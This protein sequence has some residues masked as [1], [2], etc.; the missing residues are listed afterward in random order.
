MTLGRERADQA[1]SQGAVDA[2]THIAL[3]NLY[4]A[5]NYH[6][7]MVGLRYRLGS[8]MMICNAKGIMAGRGGGNMRGSELPPTNYRKSA[9]P[10]A[11]P[12]ENLPTSMMALRAEA[13]M[14][15]A[16]PGYGDSQVSMVSRSSAYNP[17][18]I[19]ADWEEYEQYTGP[20]L[21]PQGMLSRVITNYG[22]SFDGSDGDI[23]IECGWDGIFG[24][25]E[26]GNE[27]AFL[28]EH[29]EGQDTAKRDLRGY[30]EYESKQAERQI[31][32]WMIKL[33]TGRDYG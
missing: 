10:G 22:V 23:R 28:E 12:N 6:V 1:V 11:V 27:R 24:Y 14:A 4:D 7:H 26:K 2:T 3:Q 13:T 32:A 8:A 20:P 17:T 19:F 16:P 9:T 15:E 25:D 21:A 29:F 33:A 31:I 30:T 18:P 5:L